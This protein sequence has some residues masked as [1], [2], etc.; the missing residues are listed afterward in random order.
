[1]DDPRSF[2]TPS[3][4]SDAAVRLYR[5]AQDSLGAA[6]SQDADASDREIARALAPLLASGAGATL[7][8]V[9]GGAP[10]CAV[11]R[12]LW[13]ALANVE[14]ALPAMR[15]VFAMPVVVVAAAERPERAG[16]VLPGVID[17]IGEMIAAMKAHGALAGNTSFALGNT[18]V[19]ADALA[20]ASLGSLLAWREE[21][22]EG[23]VQALPPA[24]IGV[25]GTVESVHLRY[26]V[27][28]AIAAPG[29]DLFREAAPG[30][31]GVPVA[32]ALSRALAI[33]G[34][35]VLALPRVPMP[36]VE[37]AWQGFVA[38]RDIGAQL[39]ASNAI[40]AIR[41]RTG[42]P[43]AVISVHRVDDGAGEVRLSLS[44]PLD[45]RSAEGFRWPLAPLD[46][47]DDVVAMLEGLLA[48]CRVG[49][50][51][52]MPGIHA[53]RD[54]ATGLPLLFKADAPGALH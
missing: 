34:V 22:P 10:S 11:Y 25:Q 32:Q 17:T 1:M 7:D 15:R 28:S 31:W 20:F 49:D 19:G 6:T 18:L 42:E 53:D 52:R 54:A 8:A 4:A 48:D 44:S 33:P 50:V 24:A 12:H 41:A 38:Q 5:L 51:R 26:L 40:R 14:R 29:A 45:P 16:A 21:G 9:F 13:R 23:R 36:L 2:A 37:A 46:R 3:G 39:F 27:G 47:V 35:S 30:A 43:S